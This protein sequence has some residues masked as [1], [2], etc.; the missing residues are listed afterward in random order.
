MKGTCMTCKNWQLC[1]VSGATYCKC[2]SPLR[3]AA[4]DPKTK[5]LICY[6][7]KGD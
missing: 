3:S 7:E 6:E 1:H 4:V 2:V 5:I